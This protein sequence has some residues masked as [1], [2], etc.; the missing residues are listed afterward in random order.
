MASFVLYIIVEKSFT[1]GLGQRASFFTTNSSIENV[2]E[3]AEL[4]TKMHDEG[5][6]TEEDRAENNEEMVNQ[7]YNLSTDF[8]EAGWGSSFHFAPRWKDESFEQSLVRH[9]HFIGMQAG[10]S[11]G[12]RV[13]DVGCGVGGPARNIARVSRAEVVGLNNNAYQCRRGAAWNKVEGLQGLVSFVNGSF[14]DMPFEDEEFDGAYAIEATCHAADRVKCYSE[15]FRVLKPGAAF[16]AYEWCM[17]E[18]WY[19]E[20]NEQHRSIKAGIEIG[21]G[22]PNILYT[23]EILEALEES[24][25]EIEEEAD[26]AAPGNPKRPGASDGKDGPT[27]PWFDVFRPSFFNSFRQFQLTLPGITATHVLVVFLELLGLAPKGTALMHSN[28]CR[29]AETL[30]AGGEL[31]IF[32]PCYYFRARKPLDATSDS[33]G[34]AGSKADKSRQRSGS[35][36]RSSQ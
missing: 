6:G 36:A 1:G 18:G 25:F 12:K 35:R 2:A 22:L 29:A 13:L 8:Y 15:V 28:L 4:Y 10:A 7:Y 24:G 27:V 3:Q 34:K 26:L 11:Q 32:T 14:L 17:V 19:D 31:N 21:D 33:S 30:L 9:E 5:G 20:S 23:K 16:A